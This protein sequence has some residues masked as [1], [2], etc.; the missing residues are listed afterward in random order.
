MSRTRRWTKKTRPEGSVYRSGHSERKGEQV[1]G[2]AGCSAVVMM[3]L[4]CVRFRM[5]A[6]LPQ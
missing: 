4:E 6:P 1:S 2:R 5:L 3:L